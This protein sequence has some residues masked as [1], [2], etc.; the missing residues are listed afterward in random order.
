MATE[1]PFSSYFSTN[2]PPS[3]LDAD[4]IATLIAD[5]AAAAS[6]IRARLERL[7]KEAQALQGQLDQHNQYIDEHSAI[8]SSFRRLPDYILVRIFLAN[9]GH[10]RFSPIAISHVS[11]KWRKL[12][13]DTPLMWTTIAAYIR[14]T[15]STPEENGDRA[16]LERV[17]AFI[18]R[19]GALGLS[20][21]VTAEPV[22]SSLPAERLGAHEDL[23]AI[24]ESTA[25]RWEKLHVN[26]PSDS[27]LM[28]LLRTPPAT[29]AG[30]HSLSI[31]FE[32]LFRKPG[33]DTSETASL[34][35]PTITVWEAKSL[36]YL[37]L[38]GVGKS[39][40]ETNV[41]L[42]VRWPKLTSLHLSS[43]G[44]GHLRQHHVTPIL[45]VCTNLLECSLT[46]HDSVADSESSPEDVATE[47]TLPSL[48]ALELG[49]SEVAARGLVSK[50]TL[51]SLTRLTTLFTMATDA[52]PEA[53]SALAEWIDRY[54]DQLLDVSFDYVSLT[55]SALAYC[56]AHLPNVVRLKLTGKARYATYNPWP[57]VRNRNRSFCPQS[58]LIDDAIL[59]SLTPSLG[60]DGEPG[61]KDVCFC[62]KLRRLECHMGFLERSEKAFVHLILARYGDGKNEVLQGGV[63]R[64]EEVVLSF[65]YEKGN[66][67]SVNI[68]GQVNSAVDAG[69]LAIRVRYHLPL[70]EEAAE[71]VFHHLLFQRSEKLEQAG[72]L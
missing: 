44:H 32:S 22:K 43:G 64:I 57:R 5:R 51:P 45:S 41:S 36:T 18:Q 1:S 3:A 58:A 34:V 55:Q 11:R 47:A 35:D 25:S 33:P 13:L 69:P 50:L 56:L 20:I 31:N 17:S 42:P 2:Q 16:R 29:T 27:P 54:G 66:E 4:G 65:N 48:R 49:G 8:I 21:E 24:L 38:F 53:E 67:G 59:A 60:D 10:S 70:A 28:R 62:P 7:A 37:S 15:H 52:A 63:R 9:R 68:A 40:I 46:F 23:A 30:L 71:S 72:K 26:V 14:E 6:E 19:S 12:A 61:G 39:V